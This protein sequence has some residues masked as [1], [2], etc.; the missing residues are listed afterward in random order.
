MLSCYFIPG[1][2][3]VSSLFE[4]DLIDFQVSAF[5]IITEVAIEHLQE[6]GRTMR[7][8]MNNNNGRKQ[9]TKEVFPIF[10]TMTYVRKYFY[11]P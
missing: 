5:D 11:M 2:K 1:L 6:I 4:V 7:L 8:Y 10:L 3:V 9:Y